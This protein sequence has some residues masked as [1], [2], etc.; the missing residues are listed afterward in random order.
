MKTNKPFSITIF[1]ILF[2]F[3]IF[4][5]P[6]AKVATDYH[7]SF[8]TGLIGVLPWSWREFDVADGLGE[9]TAVTL[10]SQPLTSLS[11]LLGSLS[12]ND[13]I[14]TKLMGAIIIV[15][16]ILG[17]WKLLD[18][19]KINSWGKS[20]GSMFFIL[21]S[22]FLLMFDGGQFSLT[23]AY[24]TLPFAIL[25]FINLV[26]VARWKERIKFSIWVLLLSILDIR[27]V[28]LLA[29]VL[30][31]YLI[32]KILFPLNWQNVIRILKNLSISL[33]FTLIVLLGFHSYW[34]T[35]SLLMK[36]PSLPITY[37]RLGQVNFLSFSSIGHS[38]FLQQ[39]HWYK[40]IFG[41]ISQL[42]FEFILIPLLVFLS[43]ILVKRNRILGF[44]LVIAL[45]GIFLSKGSQ[46]PLGGI[47]LWLF[48]NFPG[49]Y[50]FRDPVKFYFL[51]ALAYSVLIG[52]TVNA[53]GKLEFKNKIFKSSVKLVPYLVVLYL[54]FLARPIFL[55]WMSGMISQPAYSEEYRNMGDILKADKEL[56]RVLWIPFQSPLGYSSLDHPQLQASRLVE[57]RP[58]AIGTIGTYETFNFLREAPFMGQIFDVAGIGYIA[59]PF[60]DP[61]KDN[62][63][64]DNIKYY[65]LFSDQL[66]KRLWLSKVENSPVTLFKTKDHQD[67][68]FIPS[69][70]WWVIGS[71]TIYNESTKSANLALSKNALIF[72]EEH[73][74]LSSRLDELPEA[75]II[76]NNK[77]NV[78]LAANFINPKD[79]V[80]PARDL[81][82]EPN[83]S[84]W[85]KREAVDLIRWREFLKD[86][87]GVDN[88]DFD[89]SGG[90]AVG[91]GNKK[92]QISNIK[93][94]EGDILLARVMESS[95]SGSLKF[96]QDDQKIGE[97]KTQIDGETN[98][99]WF[100]IGKLF[101]D[102]RE[103]EIVSSGDINVVN[104]LAILDE[105]EWLKFQE[106]AQKLQ[107]RVVDFDE[108][109][110]QS[111]K[112]K[113]SFKQINPTKY[114]VNVSNLD[115]P[116]FLVFSQNYDTL[117]TLD[118][119]SPLPIY[120]LLNGFRVER[121]GEYI[122]EFIAQKYVNFGLII[123]GIT[124]GILVLLLI[125]LNK[126]S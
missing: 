34:I 10:W 100:E 38:I 85:W 123:S 29:I 49:F 57:K 20:M 126:S 19:L 58:F 32:G 87:Y 48:G 5:Y 76:L 30:T 69:N 118:Q 8:N 68:F 63:H 36:T 94:Q 67:K 9:Y 72:A 121:D 25:S 44:W 89:L 115:K 71:D 26:E 1:V 102:E 122:V 62:M 86:K 17:I 91:E 14:R 108:K 105:N 7:L 73:A 64:P 110:I 59:Y 41:Q 4:W 6:G 103:L 95:R 61:R 33:I 109:N 120:S 16:G 12:L 45:I 125:K 82:F 117:W 56:S 18:Y 75:K 84:G 43:P 99:R 79:L 83:K 88:Q 92:Y 77:T 60:L 28:F 106:K 15:F 119:Q 23:L 47:Y 116:A 93:Y 22:F 98:V 107:P 112:N 70:I 42:K 51:T 50:F 96:F 101:K 39:P 13:E 78:D 90:W 31:F 104:A 74:G 35:P 54:L 53:T 80:F 3:W 2:C 24:I 27:I 97:V 52:F 114:I 37:D 46:P 11:N 55:G 113:V 81:D 111:S 66:S 65:Y 40:N 124:I 21:N